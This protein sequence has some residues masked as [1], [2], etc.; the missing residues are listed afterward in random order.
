[1]AQITYAERINQMSNYK[2]CS[3]EEF[4][5]ILQTNYK[6]PDETGWKMY[7]PR[8]YE[9]V[10]VCEYVHP[11]FDYDLKKKENPEKYDEITK[12]MKKLRI[13]LRKWISEKLGKDDCKFAFS[14]A[15]N[16]KEGYEKVSYHIIVWNYR[17]SYKDMQKFT[18]IYEKEMKA[19]NLDLKPYNT[20]Q[21]KFRAI[22]SEKWV[23]D[24]VTKIVSYESPALV[25]I[26][27]KDNLE[28]HL[29][30]AATDEP[31]IIIDQ[32][33]PEETVDQT[34]SRPRQSKSQDLSKLNE[35][36]KEKVNR[37]LTHLPILE[38][39]ESVETTKGTVFKFNYDHNKNLCPVTGNK[40][41][42]QGIYFIGLNRSIILC[43]YSDKCSGRKKV[44][45][46]A[47]KEKKSVLPGSSI[48]T[49]E[50]IEIK[51]EGEVIEL[52]KVVKND[53]VEKEDNIDDKIILHNGVKY[54][55]KKQ[56]AN[57]DINL[58]FLVALQ[59]YELEIAKKSRG[60]AG[61]DISQCEKNKL[62][63]G[64]SYFKYTKKYVSERIFV[65]DSGEVYVRNNEQYV[66]YEGKGR[67]KEYIRDLIFSGI[68]K[69]VD[70]EHANRYIPVCEPTKPIRYDNCLNT[71]T[72]MIHTYSKDKV[73][74]E[75]T[76]ANAQVI[77]DYIL[78]ELCSGKQD[79][80][81]YVKKWIGKMVRGEKNTSALYLKGIQG[82]GK[83]TLP[84]FLGKYVIGGR[85]TLNPADKTTL[86]DKFNHELLGK[87][88][89]VYEE[90]PHFRADDWET[91]SSRLKTFITSERLSY[92]EKRMARHE[93]NN[94]NNYIIC[95][96][97]DSIKDSEGRRYFILDLS[98]KREGDVEYWKKIY[99]SKTV[100]NVKTG[101]YL[102]NYFYEACP[103][104]WD[105]QED[106]P[107]TDAKK[108]MHAKLLHPVYRFI[109]EKYINQRKSMNKISLKDLYDEFIDIDQ[110][111]E[112]ENQR[113][114]RI[115]F[116][117]KLKEV[118]IICKPMGKNI[119]KFDY[120]LLELKKIARRRNWYHELLDE[121]ADIRNLQVD[122]DEGVIDYK[123][124]YEEAY[125]NIKKEKD[126]L[127]KRVQ[128]LEDK[129]KSQADQ[130]KQEQKQNKNM[131]VV[132]TAKLPKKLTVK[133]P[134]F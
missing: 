89:V 18:K 119:L 132:K 34:I 25:P 99:D 74:S 77:L 73:F 57:P 43:C 32:T 31:L 108:D 69:W 15:Q 75:E 82:I 55:I 12:D 90:L 107:V 16:N 59:K 66:R 65:L 37:L 7:P 114:S 94:I 40:H 1:M 51:E 44:Y 110:L 96:N 42:R 88:L 6:Q 129:L 63:L 50:V 117:Q 36:E 33:I 83:S 103:E 134:G 131:R 124:D 62:C 80:F 109:K 27:N 70:S 87:T 101:E 120:S 4:V 29:V 30:S 35:D 39:D 38:F 84:V 17:I 93:E 60:I 78:E 91:V 118:S 8:L 53:K 72:R 133:F 14:S 52:D 97:K 123:I 26:D 13:S 64:E 10:A 121:E 127:L 24:R 86:V 81:E 19:V 113:M 79:Q 98:S 3:T 111:C 92:E 76:K 47:K 112:N 5:S 9:M 61:Q 67:Y 128:E 48:K 68:T 21:Q 106:M 41:D 85:C 28:R 54:E 130:P 122:E 58:H 20:G 49:N 116:N 23:V 126:E 125:Y 115:Q 2:S 11:Y 22:Y 95:S 105:S 100:S 56:M 46:R 45:D 104:N 71:Y 102:F